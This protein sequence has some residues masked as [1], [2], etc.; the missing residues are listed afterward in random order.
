MLEGGETVELDGG[1]EAFITCRREEG[2][3]VVL[4]L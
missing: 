4:Y 1:V 2:P 3:Q